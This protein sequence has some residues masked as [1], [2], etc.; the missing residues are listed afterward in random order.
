MRRSTPLAGALAFAA[1]A[2]AC[3]V[4]FSP[5]LAVRGLREAIEGHDVPALEER[6]D[7]PRVRESFKDQ[8]R[9]RLHDGSAP[10]A[11]GDPLAALAMGVVSKAVD[12]MVDALVTPSSLATLARGVRPP[13]PTAGAA[14]PA[15]GEPPRREL[16]P[17]ARLSREGLDRFSLFVPSAAGGELRF[18]FRRRGLGWTLESILLPPETPAPGPAS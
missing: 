1:A 7:F 2:V 17:D 9:E 15:T 6:V 4:A 12:V 14:P 18:V 5:W 10:D 8:I 16:F 13:L 11:A 3:W